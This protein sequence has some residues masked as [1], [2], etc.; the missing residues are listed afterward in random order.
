MRKMSL[1]TFLVSL[2]VFGGIF[3]FSNLT[4]PKV[5]ARAQEK[6]KDED[7]GVGNV[8]E[9][10]VDNELLFLVA[11]VDE[12]SD[13]LWSR[14]DTLI[15]VHVQLDSGEI[16]MISIPRDTRV[17]IDKEHGN[18]K[19]NHANAFGGMRLTMRTIREFLGID[20]DYYVEFTFD[21]VERIVDALGGVEV[22]IP[23]RIRTY[24]P[25]VNL[26]PGWQRL[27]G[28]EA[29]MFARYRKG[30]ENGDI[31]R[32]QA[33][34]HLITQMIKEILKPTNIPKLP[35]LLDVY[36]DE[37]NTN[38]SMKTLQGMLPMIT[39]FSGDNITKAYVPGEALDIDGIYYYEYDP[40]G[41]QEMVDK[42]LRKYKIGPVARIAESDSTATEE[43]TEAET[44]W[45]E[46]TEGYSEP[47][48]EWTEPSV[49]DEVTYE[50]QTPETEDE[51]Y[52]ESDE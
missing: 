37:V 34:Q 22:N 38:L 33:Q 46:E 26:F 11:G 27:D 5:Q 7:L 18:D 25:D 28:R 17:F 35:S 29:L 48:T 10:K 12:E 43:T 9:Q 16:N 42:Y 2:T 50:E 49:T 47:N 15:L 3:F 6:I 30:Y 14:T 40:V 45:T 19:I 21:S 39:N 20:L 8:I 36:Y 51:A 32:L 23:V 4:L 1:I 44:E 31:G 24:K 13:Q 41:T 52:E